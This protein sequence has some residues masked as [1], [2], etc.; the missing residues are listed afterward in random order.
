M[1][2]EP[3][4]VTLLVIDIPNTTCAAGH[5]STW[6]RRWSCETADLLPH[7]IRRLTTPQRLLQ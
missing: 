6:A 1:P 4:A 7:P 5:T 3:I 2:Y